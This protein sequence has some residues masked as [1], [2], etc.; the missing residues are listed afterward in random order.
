M[1]LWL[2]FKSKFYTLIFGPL[3]NVYA[4]LCNNCP[5]F[6]V[7]FASLCN[8][9]AVLLCN[10]T[11]LLC[12]HKQ[13]PHFVIILPRFAI[14]Q[15]LFFT[16]FFNLWKISLILS[17]WWKLGIHQSKHFRWHMCMCFLQ[18][19][20]FIFTVLFWSGKEIKRL[21]FAC[22]IENNVLKFDLLLFQ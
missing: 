13:L 10:Y 5:H 4:P 15:F 20:F 21:C 14:M 8:F 9:R 2:S 19:I 6:V 12:N 7:F 18:N 11:V 17:K 1:V 22:C 16:R 3:C